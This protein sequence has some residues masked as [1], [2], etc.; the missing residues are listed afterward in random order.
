MPFVPKPSISDESSQKEMSAEIET[1]GNVQQHR[2]RIVFE[3]K[4]DSPKPS[5]SFVNSKSTITAQVKA[6]L[7]KV[8]ELEKELIRSSSLRLIARNN[9][10]TEQT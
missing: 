6:V 10:K 4:S 5:D 9:S 3:Q 1:V 8:Y 7:A 2:N